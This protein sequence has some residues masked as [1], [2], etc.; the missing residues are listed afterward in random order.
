MYEEME[1]CVGENYMAV[2]IIS[3]KSKIIS[4]CAE[5]RVNAVKRVASSA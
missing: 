2:L 5:E 4:F 3:L 1:L